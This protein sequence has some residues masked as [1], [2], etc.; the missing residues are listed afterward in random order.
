MRLSFVFSGRRRLRLAV[1]AMAMLALSLTGCAADAASED[2]RLPLPSPITEA[3]A[4]AD[5]A[6]GRKE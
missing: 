6:L 3:A 1:P 4:L 2:A 5:W